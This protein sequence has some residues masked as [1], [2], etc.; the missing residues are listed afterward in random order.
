MVWKSCPQQYRD[1]EISSLE[2]SG[3]LD[4]EFCTYLRFQLLKGAVK[5]H[6]LM[7]IFTHMFSLLSPTTGKVNFSCNQ[8]LVE[9]PHADLV[10]EFSH[11][12]S[13]PLHL[14]GSPHAHL[15]KES[16][17]SHSYPLVHPVLK[18]WHQ[19]LMSPNKFMKN[20]SWIV[21]ESTSLH[22]S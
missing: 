6:Q 4:W 21:W 9:F 7:L 20:H 17:H 14:V 19:H 5:T 8:Y 16:S 13:Y 3:S 10:K 15:V 2:R 18:S 1:L 12:H 22:P 11:S